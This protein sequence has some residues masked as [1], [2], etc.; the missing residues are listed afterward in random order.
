MINTAN[1]FLARK[2]GVF[3]CFF[4]VKPGDTSRSE[5]AFSPLSMERAAKEED[6]NL[7]PLLGE[8][9]SRG[10]EGKVEVYQFLVG[11]GQWKKNLFSFS[12]LKH[13]SEAADSISL[14]LF[15]HSTITQEIL[16]G[17]KLW[18]VAWLTYSL[19]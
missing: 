3:L 13:Y 6:R 18:S 12:L 4:P 16:L 1:I 5:A 15:R 2:E 7:M 11:L 17:K 14:S 19:T 10:K 9:F 8:V